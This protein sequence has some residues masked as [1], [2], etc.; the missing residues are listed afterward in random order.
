MNSNTTEVP[1]ELLDQIEEYDSP[2]KW[3]HSLLRNQVRFVGVSLDSRDTFRN[4]CARYNGYCVH[5]RGFFIHTH[6][7]WIHKVIVAITIDC[8]IDNYFNEK[9]SNEWKKK[10]P[11]CFR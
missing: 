2:S 7:C 9:N 3:L 4:I 5:N 8:S 11:K 1:K 10:I 6:W